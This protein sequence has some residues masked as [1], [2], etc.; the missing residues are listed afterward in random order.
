MLGLINKFY[1]VIS[2]SNVQCFT[3]NQNIILFYLKTYICIYLHVNRKLPV[4]SITQRQ[5]KM[6]NYIYIVSCVSIIFNYF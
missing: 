3:N 6:N 4:E 5:F 1:T 2:Y